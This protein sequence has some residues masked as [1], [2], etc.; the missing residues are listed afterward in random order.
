MRR[1]FEQKLSKIQMPGG[2]P[3]GLKLNRFDWYIIYLENCRFYLLMNKN[4]DDDFHPWMSS[5]AISQLSMSEKLAKLAHKIDFL[6]DVRG[7]AEDGD[8]EDEEK[9]LVT[10]QPSLWPWDSVRENLR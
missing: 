9:S 1:E 7:Q 4:D 2:L 5:L 8:K 10:F 6:S 3:G